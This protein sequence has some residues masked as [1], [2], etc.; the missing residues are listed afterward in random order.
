M[1]NSM[2]EKRHPTSDL[3]VNLGLPTQVKLDKMVSLT[4]RW[5][6][7]KGKITLSCKGFFINNATEI[8]KILL[9]S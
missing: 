1:G 2:L 7:V 8:I 5:L 4:G 3:C 6:L 9:F